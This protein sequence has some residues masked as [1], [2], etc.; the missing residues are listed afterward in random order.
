MQA[1]EELEL[2]T[3]KKRLELWNHSE[4][5]K[6]Q[7]PNRNLLKCVKWRTLNGLR[8]GTAVIR[9]NLHRWGMLYNDLCDCEEVQDDK[10]L[11]LLARSIISKCEADGLYKNIN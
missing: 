8:N 1:I 3:E 5:R 6:E 10:H 9:K 4:A 7:L 2:P 11:H